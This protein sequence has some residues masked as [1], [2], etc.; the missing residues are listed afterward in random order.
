VCTGCE[1]EFLFERD[2]KALIHRKCQEQPSE[3]VIERLR[4]EIRR[5]M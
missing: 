3:I 5:R 4:L 1:H 2:F